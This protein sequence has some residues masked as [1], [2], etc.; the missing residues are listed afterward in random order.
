MS[1]RFG[2]TKILALGLGGAGLMTALTPIA[3]YIH[4][5]LLVA[6]RILLGFFEGVFVPS[7]HVVWSRWAPP[8]ERTKL[9]AIAF[10]GCHIGIV[11]AMFGSGALASF[12]GWPS[13]F[14]VHAFLAFLW[15]FL[16]LMTATDS[17]TD[18]NSG[19]SPEEL[20]HILNLDHEQPEK[21]DTS[22]YAIRSRV[23][24]VSSTAP[25][26]VDRDKLEAKVKAVREESREVS[27]N[28]LSTPWIKIFTSSAVWAIICAHVSHT[29]F[30]YT[31][32][33]QMAIYINDELH[34]SII[35]VRYS[36]P[37]I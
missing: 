31:L 2:P 32:V 20:A 37:F 14:Y 29:W 28:H 33:T 6:C 8:F 35:H 23:S 30:F 22:G 19:V 11:L 3:A 18:P 12:F 26:I 4:V 34:L 10:S 1:T 7:N 36:L 13:I 21:Y 17:P 16:W 24:T 9:V 27:T 15:V 25:C 5:Y